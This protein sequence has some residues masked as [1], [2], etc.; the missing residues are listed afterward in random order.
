LGSDTALFQSIGFFLPTLQ[1]EK[2]ITIY[3]KTQSYLTDFSPRNLHFGEVRMDLF[4]IKSGFWNIR[5]R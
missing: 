4:G 2:I 3:Q 1:V 5:R